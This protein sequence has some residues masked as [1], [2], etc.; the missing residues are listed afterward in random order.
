MKARFFAV[1]TLVVG[2]TLLL[3]LA[4]TTRGAEP[5]APPNPTVTPIPPLTVVVSP[6]HV[7]YD[8][9]KRW[10][11]LPEY[12]YN[13]LRPLKP[14]PQPVLAKPAGIDLDVTYISRTPMYN[15]YDLRYTS[16]GKPY[17]RPGTEND[18]R[19]PA[20][21][22]VVTFTVHIINKGT[23][24]SGNF[25]FKWFIDGSEVH[26]G[27]HS[28]LTPG[29]EATE[30][31]QWAWEHSLDGERLLGNHTVRFT[32]DP[33]NVISETYESNNSLEDRT[34]AL[35]L[36][37]AVSPELYAALETPVDAQWP[38]SAEDWLQKQIAAM[39]AAF[40]RSIYPSTPNGIIERVRLD[41]IIVTSTNP[42]GWGVDG[43][44]YMT[45]DDRI[46]N[47][48]YNR[49]TDV[50]G[51]LI[52]EL[53]HY[54][55]G[56]IDLY[57]LGFDLGT[58]R[59]VDQNGWPVQMETSLPATGL[60]LA[61]GIQPPIY[62]EHTA[63][64]LNSNKG[65]RR[66]YYGEYLYDVP[67]QS[68]LRILGNQ[69]L[70]VSGVTVKLYQSAPGYGPYPT[71]IDNIPEITGTT[72][73]EGIV[74][75]PNRPVGTPVTTRTGHTL[76]DN[77]FGVIDRRGECD[78][79]VLELIKGTHQE[80]GWLEI[81]RFNLASWQGGSIST[82]FE[83]ASHVPTDNA[84]SPPPDITGFLE[85]GLV[86]LQ[87]SPSPSAG[88]AGYNVYRTSSNPTYT[89]QRIITGTTATNYTDSCDAPVV[90]YIVTALNTQG[91]ESGFSGFFSTFRLINPSSIVV[92]DQ[93]RRIVLDPQN[94]YSLL[95]Q[96]PDGRF[97]DI[98][99]NPHY[100]LEYS[101]YL[102]RD[103]QGRLIISHP[104]D[105]YSSRHSVR[106]ADAEGNPLF[107]FGEQGSGP[108]QF[109]TPAGVAVWGQPC[110]VEGPYSVDAHTL[111]LLHFDSSY[112]GAQGEPGT[113]SGTSFM[114]GKYGQGVLID[115]NDTLTYATASNIDQARGAIEMWV[116]PLWNGN[117][118]QTHFF[119][120]MDTGH[121]NA[122]LLL[123]DG[124]NNLK[125]E[126]YDG[127]NGYVV[128][129]PAG[130]WQA[131]TSYHVA[132][133]WKTNDIRLYVDGMLVASRT[134]ANMMSVLPDKMYIGSDYL[135]IQQANAVIDEVRISD[136]TRVGNSDT[137]TYRILV[138]DSGNHRIQAFD[139]KG[140][141]VSAYGS[142]GIGSG[143]F[144]T[145]TAIAVDTEGRVI[146]ADTGNNRLQVLSFDGTN[147]GFVRS[148]TANFNVPT[149]V[150]A[151][152]SDR[153]L[154]A[155]TGNNKVKVLNAAGTLLAEYTAPNDGYTGTLNKPRGVV[156]DATGNIVVAD[157]GNRRVITVR[158][159]LPVLTPTPTKTST[160]TPTITHT[161]TPKQ[162]STPTATP[163]M[164]HTPTPTP[165]STPTRTSTPTPNCSGYEIG[166]WRATTSLPQP[167][168]VPF[169]GT[170]RQLVISNGRMYVFGGRDNSGNALA[171]VYYSTI[172][173]GG[174][175]GPWVGTTS[176]PGQYY[177]QAVVQIENYV[178]L[179]T[180]AA[181]ATAVY[182]A[183]INP[184]GSIGTW[185]Q[186]ASLNPSRQAFAAV[187][188]REYIYVSGGNSVGMRDFVQFTSVKPDGSLNHWADTT[189]LPE[190]MQ[191]HTMVAYNGRLYV[192]APNR[193]VYYAS[194]NSNGTLGSWAATTSLPQA[195]L[196]YSTFEYNGYIYLLG[197]SSRSVYYAPV[198]GDGSL[199][200]WQTTTSLPV[201]R[202]R[203]WTGAYS[204]FVYAVGGYDGSN[205]RDTVYYA[206]LQP[207]ATNTPTLTPSPTPYRFYLPSILRNFDEGW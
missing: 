10:E 77:P 68:Y 189:P 205:Y 7:P 178:Y 51:A 44:F 134:S 117:D 196:F 158:G 199:G 17:L 130:N 144:I 64:A 39:N 103:S 74:L 98:L 188:Y 82:T 71:I 167:M 78:E 153:I 76:R 157:T 131:N 65:Y 180:G 1:S 152:G 81:T 110:T 5:S 88:I 102:T 116:K 80:Y 90:A 54:G 14:Q 29:E 35:S 107:E 177:D 141:F 113:A 6:T 176:L 173:A 106:V 25:A 95:Y 175:L 34:D 36:A 204:C 11:T 4:V 109:E 203:L 45:V 161:P 33:A 171:S 24:A 21:G 48:Y 191:E 140:N 195:M 59:I 49:T 55:L 2:L 118:G 200:Q 75:L 184:D 108:G 93:N 46:D 22:E 146:V 128:G 41:K 3:A 87:W 174:L 70:P 190:A 172:Q 197:G 151:Y 121:L 63:L 79:F 133:T 83:I 136:I 32:V 147:F 72:N 198:L 13:N 135:G 170:G 124:A 186:T 42:P 47:A 164:T 127:S 40:A 56:V 122:L 96:L 58:P 138:A 16:D 89:Y 142:Q 99:S 183:P 28:S 201:Q 185:V 125:F 132:A 145:P 31:Y 43:G 91:R 53:S 181:G 38:F 155:D 126:I 149:G 60:M 112:D 187:A 8:P 119:F 94:G 20:P 26:S 23:I 85:S 52:H 115:S 57:N 15:R 182:Y 163:T 166:L 202:S 104:R 27:I 37:L 100:H 73:T 159:A 137:C 169:S 105:F 139:A 69:G 160:A 129:F 179:I 12:P 123:K 206:Q 30:T 92:D 143:Q 9:F 18:K 61:P 66:G 84:P 97:I 120:C 86:K 111:L 192:F 19:W 62:E 114:G 207:P 156:G 162:T 194:I 165:T 148:I 101:R 168:G 67:S 154:V 193:A 150:A 50:S